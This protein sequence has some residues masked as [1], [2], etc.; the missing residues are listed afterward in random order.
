VAA[1]GGVSDTLSFLH[2]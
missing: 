2:L 1:G